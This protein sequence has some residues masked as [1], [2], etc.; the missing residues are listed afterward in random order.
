MQ[1]LET[2]KGLE[3]NK[4]LCL[5][6]EMNALTFYRVSNLHLTESRGGFAVSL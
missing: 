6:L 1:V 5:I 4:V 3:L 2:E